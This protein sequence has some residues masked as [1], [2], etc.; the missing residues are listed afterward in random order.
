MIYSLQNDFQ[1]N[2]IVCPDVMLLTTS[3]SVMV[4]T[5]QLILRMVKIN[6][7]RIL[8]LTIITLTMILHGAVYF[9]VGQTLRQK[10]NT[11]VAVNIEL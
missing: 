8:C 3:L 11:W 7:N 4:H 9:L 10:L 1:N 6:W 2:P 5:E